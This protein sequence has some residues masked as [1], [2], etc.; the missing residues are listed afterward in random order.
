MRQ[1]VSSIRRR[2]KDRIDGL[3]N[4]LRR[5]RDKAVSKVRQ[6]VTGIPNTRVRDMLKDEFKKPAVVRLRDR[7][8]QLVLCLYD[9]QYVMD[10]HV[11]LSCGLWVWVD[12]HA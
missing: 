2:I 8:S 12:G 3:P 5:G 7:V 6:R 11:E 9:Y 1:K 4:K 10:F